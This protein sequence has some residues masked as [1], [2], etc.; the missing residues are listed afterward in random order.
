MYV[1]VC[2][3]VR[4]REKELLGK[5]WRGGGLLGVCAFVCVCVCVCVCACA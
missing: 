5:R 1:C 4:G 3:L 2:V